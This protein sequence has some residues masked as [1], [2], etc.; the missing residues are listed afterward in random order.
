MPPNVMSSFIVRAVITE[1]DEQMHS[2]HRAGNTHTHTNITQKDTHRQA[3]KAFSLTHTHTRTQTHT[4]Q[5]SH[6]HTRAHTHT[7][8][9]THTR[10]HTHTQRSICTLIL[11]HVAHR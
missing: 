8:T 10:T 5:P 11:S 6:P 7:H 3:Y 2:Q 9:H 4:H 1:D